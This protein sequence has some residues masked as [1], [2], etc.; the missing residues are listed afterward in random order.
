VRCGKEKGPLRA[1][2]SHGSQTSLK[3]WRRIPRSTHNVE[4]KNKN[5]PKA[6]P[7]PNYWRP[8]TICARLTRSKKENDSHR[9]GEGKSEGGKK[10]PRS[11]LTRKRPN[12]GTKEKNEGVRTERDKGPYQ[13]PHK[14]KDLDR[15]RKQ[16]KRGKSFR[17]RLG[18]HPV[19]LSPGSNSH[20][21]REGCQQKGAGKKNWTLWI[22]RKPPEPHRKKGETLGG[23]DNSQTPS[24][25]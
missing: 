13:Q 18:T 15:R 6:Q 22:R 11:F 20:C 17:T 5:H 23:K 7:P 8:E 2:G 25:G 19:V 9:N 4:K 24:I 16:P 21:I 3:K 12:W 14:K 10:I 1:A